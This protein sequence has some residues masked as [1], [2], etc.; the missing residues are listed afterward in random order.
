[1]TRSLVIVVFVVILSIPTFT[2]ANEVVWNRYG[3]LVETWHDSNGSTWYDMA[4]ETSNKF[5]PTG[6]ELWTSD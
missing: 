3:N 4:M 6:T 2:F 1:M 5:G